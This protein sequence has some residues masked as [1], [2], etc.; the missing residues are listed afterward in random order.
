[1]GPTDVPSATSK[2]AETTPAPPRGIQTVPETPTSQPTSMNSD[3][4]APS[5]PVKG[6]TVDLKWQFS[7]CYPNY[8]IYFVFLSFMCLV[9]I[10]H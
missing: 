6:I 10:Y 8:Q 2:P 7:I 4:T 3:T 1:M 9:P 5:T